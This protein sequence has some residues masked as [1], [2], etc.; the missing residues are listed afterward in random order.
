MKFE[1]YFSFEAILGDLVK[2]Q[3]AGKDVGGTLPP[4]AAVE[5][6]RIRRECLEGFA[7]VSGSG[8]IWYNARE[9]KT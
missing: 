8:E 7:A 5:R 2:W 6:G 9:C 1:D 3:L 4:R